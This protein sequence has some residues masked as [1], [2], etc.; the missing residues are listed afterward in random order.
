MT[1]LWTIRQRRVLGRHFDSAAPDLER[2]FA[3]TRELAAA[4]GR[5]IPS[6][7]DGIDLM[8]LLEHKLAGYNADLFA[9]VVRLLRADAGA[10]E[11]LTRGGPRRVVFPF[12][13]MYLAEHC[14]AER[15][16]RWGGYFLARHE[17]VR[18]RAALPARY[19][20]RCTT[21]GYE[22]LEVKLDG[23]PG[24]GAGSGPA[25]RAD[26]A[27]VLFVA[28]MNNY[29]NPMV[30]VM[31]TLVEMGHPPLALLPT[32]SENWP[33]AAD[34]PTEVGR[35]V[36]PGPAT[37]VAARVFSKERDRFARL[38]ERHGPNVASCFRVDGVD[39]WPLVALDVERFIKDYFP[40]A[41]ACIETARDLVD[42]FGITSVA[43]ARLRRATESALAAGFRSRGVPVTMLVHGHVSNFPERRFDAGDFSGA[44]RVCVWGADQARQ[45]I[46]SAWPPKP[47][48]VVAVGNPAWDQLIAG[49]RRDRVAVRS[50]LSAR[51]GLDSRV[52]WCVL[53]S[54][55]LTLDQFPEV[56]AAFAREPRAALIVK[57][58]PAEDPAWYQ[59]RLAG[60]P[61]ARVVAHAGANLH[62][63]LCAADLTMT[64]SSTTNLESLLL[65]TPVV[66]YVFGA[67]AGQD[68]AVYLE[69]YGL[70]LARTGE[71]LRALLQR[72]A[73]DPGSFRRGLTEAVGRAV[74]QTLANHA[75]AGASA[76][77][78]GLL[79]NP[80]KSLR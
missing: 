60:L 22:P 38:W 78:A 20:P 25:G 72:A 30:P 61:S 10:R 1:T 19:R 68:R 50:A 13:D 12:P 63:L 79:L 4:L 39:L 64:F 26:G 48:R 29:L 59:E 35:V 43:L 69:R 66:T 57:V 41:I 62:D 56:L 70:P 14:V 32:G 40:F 15:I 16:A 18:T 80:G 34:M 11:F 3:V 58:H 77:V 73:D 8:P 27:R 17:G 33:A 75:D 28:S 31:R 76:K 65:G 42:R 6:V 2:A 51:L 5:A 24:T 47:Q 54:Q 21:P 44:D 67:L 46:Q 9:H 55:T 45:V 74:E 36:L 53:T 49:P 23:A 7:H 71:E 52:L 37:T